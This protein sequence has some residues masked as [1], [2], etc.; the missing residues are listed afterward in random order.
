MRSR[1]AFQLAFSATE[2]NF[3]LI[4][5]LS[6]GRWLV[7]H[8]QLNLLYPSEPPEPLDPPDPPDLAPLS[9]SQFTTPS[10]P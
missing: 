8:A 6:H 3:D 1:Y 5:T 4:K 2:I 9:Q 7:S 10:F